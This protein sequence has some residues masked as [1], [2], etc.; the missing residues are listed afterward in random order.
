MSCI[1]LPVILVLSLISVLHLPF[2]C[3]WHMSLFLV[4]LTISKFPEFPFYRI[5]GIRSRALFSYFVW[6]PSEPLYYLCLSCLISIMSFPSRCTFITC[7]PKPVT[8][9]YIE[10][11]N[12]KLES[13]LRYFGVLLWHP[14]QLILSNT[15]KYCRQV[16]K[17][18]LLMK[19]MTLHFCIVLSMSS[20]VTYSSLC[21]RF[22]SCL[23]C[24]AWLMLVLFAL[25]IHFSVFSWP[26]EKKKI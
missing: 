23:S 18:G 7:V 1:L 12:N 15:T 9:V 22:K 10:V 24:A 2:Y 21:S 14:Y 3:N 13:G 5:S 19:F 25:C 11:K 4:V 26:Q 16:L 6:L 8:L 20:R 17:V